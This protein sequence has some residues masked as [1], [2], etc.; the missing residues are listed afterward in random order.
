M[1]EIDR[2]YIHTSDSS[3]GSVEEIRKWHKAK[4]WDDI[5]YHIV[6]TNGYLHSNDTYNI[7]LDGTAGMGRP[8][9]VEGAHVLGDNDTSL[10]ICVV[11]TDWDT[12]SSL[13]MSELINV[14]KKLMD[15]YDILAS[16]V[17][18][19]FE[20]RGVPTEKTCPFSSYYSEDNKDLAVKAMNI[21]RGIL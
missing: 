21:F 13:Q 19:H 7:Q 10:G 17:L 12:W 4:G 5:G 11:G 2:I 9:D 3:F 1:R 15:K 8:F 6:I 18:G 14:C 16:N 20:T